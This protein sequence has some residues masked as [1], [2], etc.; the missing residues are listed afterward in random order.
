MILYTLFAAFFLGLA[1]SRVWLVPVLVIAAVV[2]NLGVGSGWNFGSY[3]PFNNPIFVNLVLQLGLA[4]LVAS[5][6]GYAMGRLIAF[7]MGYL[8]RNF[9]TPME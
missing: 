5:V 6:I 9:R 2:I 7:V 8:A 3:K 4:N 1:R